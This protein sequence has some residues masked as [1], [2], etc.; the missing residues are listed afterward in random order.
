MEDNLSQFQVV[1]TELRGMGISF[2]KEVWALLLLGSLPESWETLKVM[3]GNI[4]L[5]AVVT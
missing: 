2:E 3:L 1:L 5:G 4:A